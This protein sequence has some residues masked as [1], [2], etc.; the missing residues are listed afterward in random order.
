M[1]I[2][3]PMQNERTCVLFAYFRF[4]GPHAAHAGR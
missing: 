4:P 2:A 1:R 3:T